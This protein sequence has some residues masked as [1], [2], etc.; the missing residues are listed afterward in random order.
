MNL[1]HWMDWVSVDSDRSSISMICVGSRDVRSRGAT[2]RV[3]HA[4]ARGGDAMVIAADGRP[5]PGMGHYL[6]LGST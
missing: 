1:R 4:L 6:E 5:M 2:D 3:L